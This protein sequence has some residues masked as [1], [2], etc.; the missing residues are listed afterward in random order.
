MKRAL[1]SVTKGEIDGYLGNPGLSEGSVNPQAER[2]IDAQDSKLQSG[3]AIRGSSPT[4]FTLRACGGWATI[5]LS[6]IR[7]RTI[8][9][10]SRPP[11]NY[12]RCGRL[13][14]D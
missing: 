9:K 7:T 14:Q 8:V 13:N 5:S 11:A 6:K 12:R 2:R 4:Y 3:L 10:T 1:W